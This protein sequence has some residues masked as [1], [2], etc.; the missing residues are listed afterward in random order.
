MSWQEFKEMALVP[1]DIFGGMGLDHH[2]DLDVMKISD[3]EEL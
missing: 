2:S 1:K 3:G